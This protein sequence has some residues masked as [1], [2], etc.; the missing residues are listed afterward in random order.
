MERYKVTIEEQGE[1]PVVVECS[2]LAL[3]C[4]VEQLGNKVSVRVVNRIV[5]IEAKGCLYLEFLSRV[6][7]FE[8][9]ETLLAY[10]LKNSLENDE[11]K[12]GTCAYE[13]E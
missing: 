7:Q 13:N 12:I 1:K 9:E 5:G 11:I 3:T 4:V 8:K 2:S 10:L 6:K